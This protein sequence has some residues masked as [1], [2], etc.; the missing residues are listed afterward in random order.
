MMQVF[1]TRDQGAPHRFGFWHD[2]VC[3]TYARCDG[4]TDERTRFIGRA[5]LCD[6]GS[7]QMT[8]VASGPIE[9]LRSASDL[10]RDQRDDMFLAV[11]L[12]GDALFTQNDRSVRQ[13]PPRP[14]HCAA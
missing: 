1:D 6:F 4:M 14:R 2:I 12:N 3:R 10:R 8:Q 9:Y 11:M 7:A 13:R 5:E